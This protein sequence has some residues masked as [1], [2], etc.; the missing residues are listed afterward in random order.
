MQEWIND[1][2][3][4]RTCERSSSSFSAT[5]PSDWKVTSLKSDIFWTSEMNLERR[6]SRSRVC[7]RS[8]S[9]NSFRRW[10]MASTD[11]FRFFPRALLSTFEICAI[12]VSIQLFISLVNS[13][14]G[15][16]VECE[17]ECDE[18]K[19]MYKP[20]SWASG[21]SLWGPTTWLSIL[22]APCWFSGVSWRTK[23]V[24]EEEGLDLLTVDPPSERSRQISVPSSQPLQP[25]TGCKGF[26]AFNNHQR[27]DFLHRYAKP[28]LPIQVDGC[29]KESTWTTLT[30][31]A[32]APWSYPLHAI[33]IQVY[34]KP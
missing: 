26:S 33:A 24:V 11:S 7:R 1:Q 3:T 12:T 31:E 32:N 34:A 18:H 28:K 23:R 20:S 14:L 25:V 16:L 15:K 30:M 27:A 2:L 13:M 17:C 9:I 5:R 6:A 8:F 4:S 19:E 10:P 21:W 22:S 29:Q